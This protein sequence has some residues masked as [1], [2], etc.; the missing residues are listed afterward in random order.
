MK[1]SRGLA[2]RCSR[3]RGLTSEAIGWHSGLQNVPSAEKMVPGP[4][5]F[6]RLGMLK[7]NKLVYS[8]TGPQ[9]G[10]FVRGVRDLKLRY[11]SSHLGWH[12]HHTEK[13]SATIRKIENWQTYQGN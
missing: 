2:V 11:C 10:L 5:L 8:D 3:A 1:R 4:S 13:K 7:V 12:I 9:I 6:G